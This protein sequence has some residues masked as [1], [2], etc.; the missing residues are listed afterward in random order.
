MAFAEKIKFARLQIF[1]SQEKFAKELG[2]SF[3]TLIEG[4]EEFVNR[5]TIDKR[6]SL[7]FA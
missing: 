5:I 4:S 1:L 3:A 7:I 6:Y 2:I